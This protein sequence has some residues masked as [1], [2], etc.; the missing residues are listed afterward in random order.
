MKLAWGVL[1]ALVWALPSAFAHSPHD[2]QGIKLEDLVAEAHLIINGEV[3]DIQYRSSQPAGAEPN[4]VPHTFVSYKIL[5]TLRGTPPG[6]VVTLRFRGG[7][8]GNGV[9]MT[10]T[11]IPFF[12]R[13]QRDVL[14]IK[15]GDPGLCPLVRCAAGR[16]R[17]SDD[18]VY[19]AW[20]VPVRS[21]EQGVQLGG[22]PRFD[23]NV[24][25]LPRPAFDRMIKL[26]EVRQLLETQFK[27]QS[28]E[29]LRRRYNAE[30]PEYYMAEMAVEGQEVDPTEREDRAPS[31]PSLGESIRSGAFTQAIQEAAAGAKP[32]LARVTNASPEKPFRVAPLLPERLTTPRTAPPSIPEEER[33]EREADPALKEGR[34]DG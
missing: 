10:V 17:I 5:S 29:D 30:T 13:G 27:G 31:P 33:K 28:L 34:T 15:A 2:G 8:E 23:L 12:A 18:R 26:P 1:V 3:S 21:L 24:M 7:A 25:E 9:F 19:N 32:P 22:R 14:F 20:G 11:T 4:G 16:Y 6:D